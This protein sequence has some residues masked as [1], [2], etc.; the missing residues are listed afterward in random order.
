M[1]ADF[2]IKVILL[3]L[4]NFIL[5]K[6]LVLSELTLFRVIKYSSC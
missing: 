4:L 3:E 5:T 2:R 1:F 6:H